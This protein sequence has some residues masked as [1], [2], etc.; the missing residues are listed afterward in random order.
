M[1][2]ESAVKS[3]RDAID[4]LRAGNIQGAI[5]SGKSA[6]ES[7]KEAIAGGKDVRKRI[8]RKP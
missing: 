2:A 3:G 7:G 8:Q 6:V 5:E 4:S 1:S